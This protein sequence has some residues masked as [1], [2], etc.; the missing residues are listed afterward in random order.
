[1]S[2]AIA[3]TTTSRPPFPTVMQPQ[4]LVLP[5]AATP[6]VM[7]ENH[8]NHEGEGDK[9]IVTT[10]VALA[11]PFPRRIIIKSWTPLQVLFLVAALSHPGRSRTTTPMGL[12]GTDDSYG[13]APS[14]RF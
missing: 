8:C 14:I 1:M 3:I 11:L 7:A 2:S 5:F 9:N 13:R 10:V 12:W 6:P 4:A